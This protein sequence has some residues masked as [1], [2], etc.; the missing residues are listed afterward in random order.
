M[1][2]KLN[3]SVTP[4]APRRR[5]GMALAVCVMGLLPIAAQADPPIFLFDRLPVPLK[6]PAG[7]FET[8]SLNHDGS[9]YGDQFRLVD[10]SPDVTPAF[11]GETAAQEVVFGTCGNQLFGGAAL[12]DSHLR[13]NITIQFFPTGPTTAHFVVIQHTLTGD[14]A[15]LSAPLGYKFPIVQNQV[16]DAMVLSS[17]DLDLTTGYANPNTLV[18]NSY[19]VNSGLL[20]IGKVNP[21]LPFPVISFPGVRGTAW[22]SFA[23]RPDGLLDFYFRGS[24]FLALG[25]DIGGDPVRFPLPYCD[26]AAHCVSF[27]AR[28]VSFHPHLQLDTRDTLGYTPC[29]PNCPEFPENSVQIYT[30]NSR[31]SSFGDDFELGIPQQGGNAPGRAEL[32]GRI[33]FQFGTRSG[34]T[35][36]FQMSLM[37][38]EGLFADPPN[39]PLL[40]AGFRGFLLGANQRLTFPNVTY[41]Q[42]KL[43]FADEVHNRV[44]GSIDL[45]SGQIIGEFLYPMYIDQTIIEQLLPDNNGR[46]TQ[47]PFLL[48]AMR[49]PQAPNDPNYALFEKG[50]NGQTLFRANLFHKRS[51]ETYCFPTP[52]YILGICWTS[53]PGGGG[54]LNI[55]AK[56]QAAHLA[57]PGNPGSAV[58]ADKQ[59]F[60]SPVGDTFSYDFSVACSPVGRPASL[61]YTNNNSG[62]SGGT[63]T[64]TRLASVSCTNSRTSIAA[65]GNYDH[66]AVTGFGTWSKDAVAGPTVAA[67]PNSPRFISASFS[68]DPNARYAN[69]IVF[70]NYPG[71]NRTLPGALILPGDDIDVAL[72]TAENKPPVKP[73]P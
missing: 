54:N 45:T 47:D 44:S 32:Q 13:G 35:L 62:P 58:M 5:A 31:Y 19:F 12:F 42:H 16:S 23:Q 7:N 46:V 41:E 27:V 4:A 70:N 29:A 61:L 9:Y 20:A 60:T 28:G 2:M 64:L 38:P 36:P 22:A 1:P 55:F 11:P 67:L 50:A 66:V 17:G 52:A 65:P 59:T 8:L 18:W 48:A 24:T 51:F 71:E 15:I 49:A 63:F 72:S 10:C 39:S 37:P 73:V 40:G 33:Q 53:P 30:V 69:V 34:N 21:K 3:T 57:D 43:L 56:L 14:N 6:L 26:Q 25:N 68:T